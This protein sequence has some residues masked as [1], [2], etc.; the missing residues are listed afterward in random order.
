MYLILTEINISY[1][2]RL[3]CDKR[4]TLII[5]YIIQVE[6][7]ICYNIYRLSCSTVYLSYS[8]GVSVYWCD[9]P[10]FNALEIST[11]FHF[12]LH[13]SAPEVEVKLRGC[14][15]SQEPPHPTAFSQ[16][17]ACRPPT[18]SKTHEQTPAGLLSAMLT[19]SALP[20]AGRQQVALWWSHVETDWKCN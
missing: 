3:V 10:D 2:T 13:L 1:M 15:F 18:S 5:P 20:T 7:N 4:L 14:A 9:I 16:L 12:Y 17:C 8:I 19:C 6:V 11:Y